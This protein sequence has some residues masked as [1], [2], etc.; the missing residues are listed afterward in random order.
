MAY[1]PKSQIKI[2]NTPGGEFTYK[3][4]SKNYVGTYIETS[5]GKFY[6]GGDP[7]NLTNELKRPF[8]SNVQFGGSP[9]VTT[10][11]KLQPKPH[12]FLSKT[13]PIISTKPKPTEEDY[14]KGHFGRFFI[15]KHNNN[16]DY[17]EVNPETYMD[18]SKR[19][20][21]Y[22]HH[23]YKKGFIQWA[24]KGDVISINNTNIKKLEKS[25]PF[26]YVLFPILNEFQK[27]KRPPRFKLPTDFQ[28][29]YPPTGGSTSGGGGGG[30]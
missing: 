28:Y 18:L 6:A 5:N 16:T 15:K 10:H 12:K 25:F 4:T 7:T 9:D 8:V 27:I 19:E 2:Q 3:L 23:L 14:K 21:M 30:Y 17:I 22:D 29:K 13:S 26:L 1:L 24:L 20:G 11:I